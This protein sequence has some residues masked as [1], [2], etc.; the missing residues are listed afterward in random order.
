[1]YHALA[2]NQITVL[3][4][5]GI[6]GSPGYGG[7]LLPAD[8][9]NQSLAMDDRLSF[10]ISDT[11]RS[12]KNNL[13]SADIAILVGYRLPLIHIER[14]KLFPME[15]RRQPNGNFYWY[16]KAPQND[17]DAHTYY[18]IGKPLYL[19][20]APDGPQTKPNN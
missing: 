3:V 14:D 1:V 20:T 2:I 13:A 5:G 7:A 18:K 10:P 11:I 6:K 17:D 16:A 19:H 4:G 9:Q 8:G 12:D 15:A